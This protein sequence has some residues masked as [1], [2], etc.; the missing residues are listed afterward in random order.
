MKTNGTRTKRATKIKGGNKWIS[1][2]VGFPR[3]HEKVLAYN[4]ESMF[5]GYFEPRW[6]VTSEDTGCDLYDELMGDCVDMD[7]A[8]TH[9]RTLP[10]ESEADK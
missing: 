7:R 9:W 10:H 2:K 4:G 6:V 5:V 1:T 8:I 3:P